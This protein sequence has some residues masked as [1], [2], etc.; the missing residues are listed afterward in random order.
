[1]QN[2][3]IKKNQECKLTITSLG[4]EGQGVGRTGDFV[5]F[6]ADTL[7]G[8]TVLAQI[9]KVGKNYAI[10]KLIRVLEP[11]PDRVAPR[12]GLAT[13]C[14]GCTLQHMRYERQL[15]AKRQIVEDALVRL[16]GF[17]DIQVQ[18]TLGMDEPWRY[19]NKGSF[20]FGEQGGQAAIGLFAPRSH[21]LL[22]VSDC[23]IQDERVMRV[24]KQAEV[25]ANACDLPAYRE[26][27]GSGSLRHVVVRATEEG[28]VTAIIVTAK[29]LSQEKEREL[30]AQ[31]VDVDSLHHS[32]NDKNTNVIF[33]DSFQLLQGKSSL[34]TCIG[35]LLFSVGPA[36]FLQVNPIQTEKLYAET[37]RLLAPKTDEYIVDIYCGIGT[38]SLLAASRA[39]HVI[40]IENVAA[41]VENA[42]ENATLNGLDNVEFHRGNAEEVLP[43]LVSEGLRLSAVIVDPPRKGCDPAVLRAIAQSGAS[44]VAY[45]SCNPATLARDLK[46]LCADGFALVHVQPVDMFP[47]TAHVETVVLLHRT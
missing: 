23:I 7:P 20:P 29:L 31:L 6:V 16:G 39:A 44:R 15:D 38:L 32:F 47:Q 33:G 19:R 4:S 14:G 2:M 8:E 12:C 41:A 24:A 17:A 10:G 42:R 43:K 36:S 30:K 9:I 35:G 22:P 28:E 45:I 3:E 5:V 21:R 27:D 46:F 13:L 26:T 34:Q 18:A 1:M 37:M 11:S 25:W 40:G